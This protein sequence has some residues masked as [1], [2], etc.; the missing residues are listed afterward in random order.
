[1][2]IPFNIPNV[3][4]VFT[5][6]HGLCD[7][8]ALATKDRH[9]CDFA[10]PV[11]MQCLQQQLNPKTTT[12]LQPP[13]IV[14]A[15]LTVS[16]FPSDTPR[17]DCDLNRW[18]CSDKLY[19]ERVRNE[20]QRLWQL[21]QQGLLQHV[22]VID[23]HSFPNTYTG[24][25]V[26]VTDLVFLDESPPHLRAPGQRYSQLTE[27]LANY[28]RQRT[29]AT[30]RILQGVFNDIIEEALHSFGHVVDGAVLVEFNE[31]LTPQ[32]ICHII[33]TMLQFFQS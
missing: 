5:E 10:D 23:L 32:Q 16:L 4:I 27:T 6:P 15:H 2:A 1:M 7:S 33:Q 8:K 28:V 31:N 21:K 19:R 12:P 24:Y 30:V 17:R 13:D 26:P 9:E 25:S 29:G 18:W 22:Y 20:Y 14:R 11:E 3:H